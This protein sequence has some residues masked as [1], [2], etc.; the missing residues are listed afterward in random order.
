M[1][2]KAYVDEEELKSALEIYGVLKSDFIWL[3]YKKPMNTSNRNWKA[4]ASSNRTSSDSNIKKPMILL[5][6]KMETEWSE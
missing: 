6:S 5:A 2:L 1:G 3:K 4:M